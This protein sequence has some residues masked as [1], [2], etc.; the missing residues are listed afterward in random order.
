[1]K[2]K[3][4]KVFLS[5]QDVEWSLEPFLWR[6]R[7]SNPSLPRLLNLR[8]DGF[9]DAVEWLN[10]K[11]GMEVAQSQCRAKQRLLGQVRSC[12]LHAQDCLTRAIPQSWVLS[13]KSATLSILVAPLTQSHLSYLEFS[14][15]RSLQEEQRRLKRQPSPK[16][17]PAGSYAASASIWLP[18][19]SYPQLVHRK[20]SA[21]EHR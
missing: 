3:A 5:E 12:L 20:P 15:C 19:A 21:I 16:G 6:F 7:D 17:S 4:A 13:C 1:M 18:T 10:D 8:A 11:R 9:F 2:P 14:H